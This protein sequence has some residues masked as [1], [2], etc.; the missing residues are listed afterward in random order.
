MN[1]KIYIGKKEHSVHTFDYTKNMKKI[2]EI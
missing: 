2:K 1:D